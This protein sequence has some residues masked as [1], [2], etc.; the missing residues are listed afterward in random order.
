MPMIHTIQMLK[1]TDHLIT[2]PPIN[3]Y[4]NIFNQIL[5]CVFV[6]EPASHYGPVRSTHSRTI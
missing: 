2:K 3:T 1:K 6:R 5:I 4:V